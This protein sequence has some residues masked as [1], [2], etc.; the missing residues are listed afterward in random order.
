MIDPTEV[1]Q[2]LAKLGAGDGPRFSEIYLRHEFKAYRRTRDGRDQAVTIEV[3][4]AG[5]G[6]SYSRFQVYATAEDGA[7]AAGN[8]DASIAAAIAVVHWGDLDTPR[9]KT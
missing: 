8:P 3:L 5:P 2:L 4:D 6:H 9:P 7:T 1:I